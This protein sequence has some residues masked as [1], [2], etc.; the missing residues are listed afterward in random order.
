MAIRGNL[1]QPIVTVANTDT[2]IYQK[3]T[4]SV[5]RYAVT[6]FNCFNNSSSAVTINVFVS[7]NLTSASGKK[8][9]QYSIPA[10]KDLDINSLIGQGLGTGDDINIIAVAGTTGVINAALTITT[11]DDGS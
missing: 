8:I 6:A 1:G 2:T 4:S 11:Y 10:N 3:P 5:Q 9:G 7:P